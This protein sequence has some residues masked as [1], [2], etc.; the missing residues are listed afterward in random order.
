MANN[1]VPAAQKSIQVGLQAQLYSRPQ[2]DVI[3]DKSLV[4]SSWIAPGPIYDSAADQK[5]FSWFQGNGVY[6][7]KENSRWV[8]LRGTQ[9]GVDSL[10]DG[11]EYSTDGVNWTIATNLNTQTELPVILGKIL[12]NLP[13][14]LAESGLAS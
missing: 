7:S 4:T 13:Q 8:R 3:V 14:N 12:Q 9:Y 10:T 5:K 11:L 1:G 2:T 6:Y